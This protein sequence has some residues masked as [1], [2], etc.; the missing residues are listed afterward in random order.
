MSVQVTY[1]KQFL[2]FIILILVFLVLVEISLQ[3]IEPKCNFINSE[4]FSDYNIFEKNEMCSSYQSLLYDH[5][6]PIPYLIPSQHYDNLNINSYGFR[7]DEISN[8]NKYT[9]IFLGGST[10]FGIVTS[11]DKTT[12]PAFL[13]KKLKEEN[14]DVQVI[15]AGIPKATSVDELYL[16][17]TDL[18]KYKPNLVIMYDGW[19]DIGERNKIK[20]NID[21]EQYKKNSYFENY[22]DISKNEFQN[23]TKTKSGTGILKFFSKIDYK[24]GIGMT[25]FIR[26]NLILNF[27]VL[28]NEYYVP[29][30]NFDS[31]LVQIEI[32][33]KNNWDKVCN[34]GE[35]N[36]FQTVNILQP[37]LGT[38]SR[39]LSN[40][41]IIRMSLV[42]YNNDNLDYLQKFDI[43]KM[44]NSE[45]H[46]IIDLRDIFD[47]INDKTVYFDVV[48]VSD[49]GNKI[50]SEKIYEK[51][52]P[53]VIKN[54][55]K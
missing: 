14:L 6:N 37:S 52:L 38:G 10:V 32:K 25:Y 35:Q 55:K 46:N 15:N 44:E 4:I 8:E 11:S 53:I 28:K 2:L 49:F 9:I 16:L 19:N 36:S 7:G 41:E 24:T 34:M 17:E 1:K 20:L 54:I 40:E 29:E 42:N 27:N 45:C 22:E 33:L 21:Y 31:N 30:K 23:S 48:H 5:S 51:I 50:I 3:I 12:I 13:E 26:D 39:N 47:E 18:L 43:G